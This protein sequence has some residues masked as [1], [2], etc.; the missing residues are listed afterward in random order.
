[1]EHTPIDLDSVLDR[2]YPE[3]T[4]DENKGLTFT[5]TDK[6]STF[7]NLEVPNILPKVVIIAP[8]A[9]QQVQGELTVRIAALDENVDGLIASAE[10]SL[11]GGVFLPITL[12]PARGV[13]VTFPVN[14]SGGAHSIVVRV[15]DDRNGVGMASVSFVYI[16]GEDVVVKVDPATIEPGQAY[17]LRIERGIPNAQFT[18]SFVSGPSQ[19]VPQ[20]GT[21]DG[22]GTY[23]IT[24]PSVGM[25]SGT[26]LWKFNF[27]GDVERV[28]ELN[29]KALVL[30]IM[31]LSENVILDGQE[32]AVSLSNGGAGRTWIVSGTAGASGNIATNASGNGTISVTPQQSGTITLTNGATVLTKEVIVK[33]GASADLTL[34]PDSVPRGKTL[35]ATITGSEEGFVYQMGG[36][37]GVYTD[38]TITIMAGGK[39]SVV[40]APQQSGT[41]TATRDAQVLSENV[42]VTEPVYTPQIEVKKLNDNAFVQQLTQVPIT[43]TVMVSMKGARPNTRVS[44]YVE[45]L[46][47]GAVEKELLVKNVGGVLVMLQPGEQQSSAQY[48]AVT[49]ANGDLTF[50]IVPQNTHPF[51]DDDATTMA[52]VDTAFNLKLDDNTQSNT[53]SIQWARAH[54]L[55]TFNYTDNFGRSGMETAQHAKAAVAGRY[56]QNLALDYNEEY[57]FLY[58]NCGPNSIAKIAINDVEAFAETDF[59]ELKTYTYSGTDKNAVAPNVTLDGAGARFHYGLYTD[60]S[61]SEKSLFVRGMSGDNKQTNTVYL[62]YSAVV[63]IVIDQGWI[64]VQA[65]AGKIVYDKSDK[66]LHHVLNGQVNGQD[67]WKPI[68]FAIKRSNTTTLFVPI[69]VLGGAPNAKI[70]Y[71]WDNFATSEDSGQTVQ[72]DAK[73]YRSGSFD[74]AMILANTVPGTTYTLKV[75]TNNLESVINVQVAV[76][77][78][79]PV[80]PPDV[81]PVVTC[82]FNGTV[83]VYDPGPNTMTG[84]RSLTTHNNINA[85]PYGYHSIMEY[86]LDIPETGSYEILLQGD[87]ATRLFL[88]CAAV[89]QTLGHGNLGRVTKNLQKGRY[90]VQLHYW[91]LEAYTPAYASFAIR[92][93]GGTWSFL[94][95]R[96]V[97]NWTGFVK[98]NDVAN[99]PT[100]TGIPPAL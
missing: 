61:L 14:T 65:S 95:D 98:N 72:V 71:S 20:G 39:G 19:T 33:D 41:I 59:K 49:D 69:K 53:C 35:V 1:M 84:A 75:R 13:D 85:A 24:S 47:G 43:E 68:K 62:K 25:N 56:T 37:S 16:S 45:T 66:S 97:Q 88:N 58:Q 82:L 64:D 100:Y 10:Y 81:T 36:T 73:G 79:D 2:L 6:N 3:V 5:A 42:T 46:L 26:Y 11:D 38:K 83:P 94:S 70:I 28:V 60:P 52:P 21:L 23:T 96:R 51:L 9:N 22:V 18:T 40:L 27:P 57:F 67:T 92:K 80:I 50:R 99:L 87:D 12:V 29:V 90:S 48:F 8:F 30:P 54:L 77:E 7:L 63:G 55:K 78:G 32:I 44:T 91:N 93:V 76:T 34:L 17:T 31:T 74:A 89:L 4:V 15:R 86:M